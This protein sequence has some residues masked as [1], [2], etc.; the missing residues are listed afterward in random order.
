MT[1]VTFESEFS[2]HLQPSLSVEEAFLK[3]KKIFDI[4]FLH[5]ENQI[6]QI[7]GDGSI[8]TRAHLCKKLG[9]VAQTFNPKAGEAQGL[10]WGSLT[11]LA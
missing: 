11:S 5:L 4:F 10:S 2:W 8:K 9:V 7:W 3:K 6:T 1:F